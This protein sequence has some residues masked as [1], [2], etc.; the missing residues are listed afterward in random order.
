MTDRQVSVK[1]RRIDTIVPIQ[2]RRRCSRC[3]CSSPSD[4]KDAVLV[5]MSLSIL[6][7]ALLLVQIVKIQ[8]APRVIP[9]AGA[10]RLPSGILLKG[11]VSNTR[12]LDPTQPR[13]L[14]ELRNVDQEFRQYDVSTRIGEQPVPDD[15]AIPDLEFKIRRVHGRA[16]MPTSIGVPQMSVFDLNGEAEIVL[17]LQQGKTEKIRIGVTQINQNRV[18]V[19]SLTHKWKFGMALSALPDNVLYPGLLEK[20]VGF[21]EGGVRLNMAGM[22]TDAGRVKAAGMLLDNVA[23]T[24]PDLA[25]QVQKSREILRKRTANRILEELQRSLASGQPAKAATRARLFPKNDLTPQVRVSVQDIITDYDGLKRRLNEATATLKQLIGRFEDPSQKQQA[26]EMIGALLSDLDV[27]NIDRLATWELL[28]A[29]NASPP[30]SSLSL[31]VS[32][33]LLGADNA[34]EGFAECY[35]LFQIR[36]SIADFVAL[37]ESDEIARSALTR[38]MAKMEGFTVDRVAALIRQMPPPFVLTPRPADDGSLRFQIPQS[39]D[40][41]RCTG[42]VPSEYT[43]TRKYPLII[44]IPR[45]GISTEDTLQ[46][47]ARQANRFGFIVAVPEVLPQTSDQY[48][49][50]ATVHSQM[51]K[52]MRKLK[53]GL[54][55]DD[56]RIFIGGHGVGGNIAMDV[57]S[58]HPELFAGVVSLAGLGRHHLQW[59]AHNSADLAWYIVVGERQHAWFQRMDIL[60]KRLFTRISGIKRFCNVMLV[61]YPE[62]GFESFSEELPAIFEWMNS[63]VRDPW[64]TEI[65]GRT[66][67]STDLSWGWLRLNSLPERFQTLEAP[68]TPTDSIPRYA[69]VEASLAKN[70]AIRISKAP[71]GGVILLSS[72]MPGIDPAK[73]VSIRGKGADK[74]I[75]FRPSVRDMLDEY[76]RTGERSRLVQMKVP[77]GR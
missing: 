9:V 75:E 76:A 44:A 41:Y 29:D 40:R 47:W 53:L 57:A 43:T 73:K 54:Q 72:E 71:S 34:I 30:E 2:L 10:V 67:R 1:W 13:Q 52:L 20:A 32:G 37:D 18:I 8:Q 22:L 7:Q 17:W 45:Q 68:T 6:L 16:R 55:V 58:S 64:P 39:V 27:H 5:S 15:N 3:S 38:Q 77:F 12:G 74:R 50:D 63:T 59:S 46:W 70:N 35:G 62:R 69:T 23:E 31:A 48:P 24:F 19:T 26:R 51:L 11:M 66:M 56:N 14:L 28:G 60:L 33:W 61:R 36:Q 25:P 21:E 65:N 49:A 42:I 4:W